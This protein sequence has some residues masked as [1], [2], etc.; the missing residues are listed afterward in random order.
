MMDREVGML[1][2]FET[3]LSKLGLYPTTKPSSMFTGCGDF[4]SPATINSIISKQNACPNIWIH[5]K[6]MKKLRTGRWS[7]RQMR[8]FSTLKNTLR[9]PV[10]ANYLLGKGFH[11]E[12]Y[13]S[14]RVS[15]MET[16]AG[17]GEKCYPSP[18]L[19][20]EHRKDLS[21]LDSSF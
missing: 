12:I 7:K 1:R 21:R 14:K 20:S 10:T 6:A 13:R 3:F 2:D 16:D 11:G 8:S 17:G 15:S 5:W 4:S 9:C 19:L 18:A